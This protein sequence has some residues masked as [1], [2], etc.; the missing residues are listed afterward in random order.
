MSWH[1]PLP[2]F[3]SRYR[4]SRIAEGMQRRSGTGRA[5][6][7]FGLYRARIARNLVAV[8]LGEVIHYGDVVPLLQQEAQS[9]RTN[10]SG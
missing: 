9:V 1:F 5:T 8:A 7:S 3:H 6:V 4:K 10:I 2:S